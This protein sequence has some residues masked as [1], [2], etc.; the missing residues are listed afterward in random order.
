MSEALILKLSD[1]HQPF[2]VET[3]ASQE[4]IDAVLMQDRRPITFLSKKLGVKNQALSTYE[5]ELLALYIVVIKWRHYLLSREFII[6]NDQI[7]LKYLLEQKVNTPM[8]H[9]GLSKLL[10]LTYKIEY[11]K[12]V[13]NKVVDALSRREG[14]I[15][16]LLVCNEKIQSVSELIPR[17]M[18]EIRDSYRNDKWI[19]GL[20]SKLQS[21][22]LHGSNPLLVEHA[23][24]LR[25]KGRICVGNHGDW[26]HKILHEFHDSALGGHSGITV[27]YQRVKRNFYWPLLRECVHQFVQ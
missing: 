8:Q 21:N 26:R 24:I 10:G 5:N 23:G 1:F 9:R 3:D 16:Q 12:G 14:H 18:E 19:E 2:V 7:S 22:S 17:W 15:G 11:K 27:T 13:E 20:R 25:Y 6:K 4:G